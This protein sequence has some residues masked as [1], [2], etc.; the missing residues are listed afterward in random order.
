VY[1]LSVVWPQSSGSHNFQFTGSK[2][3]LDK[4]KTIDLCQNPLT[5][6][7]LAQSAMPILTHTLLIL[8]A[9]STRRSCIFSGPFDFGSAPCARLLIGYLS[10][11]VSLPSTER[12]KAV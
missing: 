9:A 12:T 10:G 7:S 8:P 11:V 6:S 4:A 1:V 5:V 2:D 3:R